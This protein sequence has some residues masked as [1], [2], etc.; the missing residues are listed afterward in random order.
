MIFPKDA[1]FLSNVLVI[2]RNPNFRKF[3]FDGKEIPSKTVAELLSTFMT[4]PCSCSQKLTLV[5]DLLDVNVGNI[6]KQQ[7]SMPSTACD[8]GLQYKSLKWVQLSVSRNSLLTSLLSSNLLV[9]RSMHLQFFGASVQENILETIASND[10][11]Q[12]HNLTLI[13][14]RRALSINEKHLESILKRPSL[15]SLAL[16]LVS[17][18]IVLV[19]ALGV[20][21]ELGTLEKLSLI[22]SNNYPFKFVRFRDIELLLDILFKLP[23]ISQFSFCLELH[24]FDPQMIENTYKTWQQ[25]GCKKLK[26]FAFDTE[27]GKDKQFHA[28]HIGFLMDEMQLKSS[29]CLLYTSPSP[30]DAT[31]SRMPSSA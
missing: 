23:Q 20:Q 21:I 9:L 4:I 31:L 5:H 11:L 12:I 29:S 15:K 24:S 14:L 19:N 25:N 7:S 27:I 3:S 8:S 2:I 17:N 28:E 13:I 10:A 22:L 18:L 26:E 1:E 6:T 30:R 16:D